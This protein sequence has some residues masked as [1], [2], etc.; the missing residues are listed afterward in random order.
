M[1][2]KFTSVD[3]LEASEKAEG[4]MWVNAKKPMNV[5]TN[6]HM[7]SLSEWIRKTVKSVL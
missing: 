6:E 7:V 4:I 5:K 3:A 1:T 2:G